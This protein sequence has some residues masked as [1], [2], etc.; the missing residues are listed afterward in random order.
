MQ[1]QLLDQ[2]CG[3]HPEPVQM[4]YLF[5]YLNSTA[6]KHCQ[7]FPKWDKVLWKILSCKIKRKMSLRLVFFLVFWDFRV[8][9]AEEQPWDE[10][11]NVALWW[12]VL[13][14]G[15]ST[16]W[17][18]MVIL[19]HHIKYPHK[20]TQDFPFPRNQFIACRELIL[21][22]IKSFVKYCFTRGFQNK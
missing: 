7:W 22:F 3:L 13:L 2:L 16:T 17:W 6:S 14:K 21:F 19:M 18:F 5:L 15:N 10:H 20:K 11:S 12:C 4:G 8:F 9:P 1:H